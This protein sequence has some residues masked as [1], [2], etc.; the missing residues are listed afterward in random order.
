MTLLLQNTASTLTVGH[1]IFGGTP[2][3]GYYY[4]HI[5]LLLDN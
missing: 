1:F 5:C 4:D 3:K 2:S